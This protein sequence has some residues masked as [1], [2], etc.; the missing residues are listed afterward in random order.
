VVVVDA[1][2]SECQGRIPV[3][4]K[5]NAE[6]RDLIEQDAERLGVYRS[7]V[8]RQAFDTYRYLREG[9]FQCP[10]CANKISIEP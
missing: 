2:M 7:E 10:H 9:E 6:M 5:V 3:T 4:A 8:A 1:T